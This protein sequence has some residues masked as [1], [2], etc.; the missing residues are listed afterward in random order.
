MTMKT[1]I[2]LMAVMA[3]FAFVQ[4]AMAQAPA[5]AP[6]GATGMCKDGTY[7]TGAT[8]S[9]ACKGHQGVKD[10]YAAA[11]AKTATTPAKTAAAAPAATP[12]PAAAHAADCPDKTRN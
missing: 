1:T 4:V 11:P 6:A 7:W 10:W 8:K 3:G 2:R 12:A 9:G 5:G